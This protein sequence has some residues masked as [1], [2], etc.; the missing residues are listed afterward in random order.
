[1]N[2]GETA[3]GGEGGAECRGRFQGVFCTSSGVGGREGRGEE[4]WGRLKGGA[5]W[6]GKG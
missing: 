4:K 3:G 5:D 1:M 2:G 6:V